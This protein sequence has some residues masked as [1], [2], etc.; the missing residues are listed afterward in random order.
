MFILTESWCS[1]K[2]LARNHLEQLPYPPRPPGL[3]NDDDS[4]DDNYDNDDYSYDNDVNDRGHVHD[5]DVDSNENNNI[6]KKY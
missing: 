3:L 1:Y 2:P 6:F 5:D 4:N